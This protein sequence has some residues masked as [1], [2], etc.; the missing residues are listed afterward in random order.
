MYS[1]SCFIL[2]LYPFLLHTGDEEA[3]ENTTLQFSLKVKCIKN[4]SAPKNATDPDELFI[5]S[6][7][8]I[9]CC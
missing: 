8:E 4:K 7:G 2:H 1:I 5:H 3:K 6:K 9:L